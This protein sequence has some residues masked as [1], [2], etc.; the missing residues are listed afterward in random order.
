MQDRLNF[1]INGDA[2]YITYTLLIDNYCLY[3]IPTIRTDR[4]PGK[5]KM[6]VGNS[7]LL[8]ANGNN[9]LVR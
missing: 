5:S 8:S 2:Y 1:G 4:G 9:V 6:V 7:K 3:V